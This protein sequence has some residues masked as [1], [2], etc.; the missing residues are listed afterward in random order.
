M[1]LGANWCI[2]L[3]ISVTMETDKQDI[4]HKMTTFWLDLKFGLTENYII[5]TQT[6]ECH[7]A[8]VNGSDS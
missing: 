2:Y 6:K 1:V 8:V 3:Q 7:G 4:T 5:Y